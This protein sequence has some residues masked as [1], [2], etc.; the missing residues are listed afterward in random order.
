MATKKATSK[1]AT[2]QFGEVPQQVTDMMATMTRMQGHM[3]D[4]VM[5]QNIEVL[6]FLKARFERDRALMGEL[7]GAEDPGTASKLW[8]DFMQQA[9]SDYSEETGK[10]TGMMA[11]LTADAVRRMNDEAYAAMKT[12]EP[13]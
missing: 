13:A 7:A 6:D 11:E 8:S 10:L 2:P 9:M 1:A 12:A 5:R 3:F 4:T